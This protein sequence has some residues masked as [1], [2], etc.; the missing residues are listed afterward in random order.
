MKTSFHAS[1]GGEGL[2]RAPKVPGAWLP[3]LPNPHPAP[4]PSLLPPHPCQGC[5]WVVSQNVAGV[6]Q[7]LVVLL[8]LQQALAVVEDQG[9]DHLLQLQPLNLPGLLLREEEKLSHLLLKAHPS[10]PSQR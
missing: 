7:H 2:L 5:T 1:R 4:P 6:L 10:P 9:I 3:H 8:L